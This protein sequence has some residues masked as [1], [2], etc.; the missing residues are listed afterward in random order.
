MAQKYPVDLFHATKPPVIAK[1]EQEFNN[2]ER[3]GYGTT[4]VHQHYPKDL[5]GKG[6]TAETP[7]VRRVEDPDD[8]KTAKAE[9]YDEKP[10]E[11]K[12]KKPPAPA[13]TGGQQSS[14]R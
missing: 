5:Y 9:G 7:D 10:P 4:Y 14:S 6:H 13:S 8:E 11:P 1:N 2:Y 3:Q 12:A